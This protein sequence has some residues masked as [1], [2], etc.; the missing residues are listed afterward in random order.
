MIPV[1]DKIYRNGGNPEV[2]S[3]IPPGTRTVLD[4]G[5]GAGDNAAALAA[6]GVVVDG[7]TLSKDEMMMSR[8]FCRDVKLHNLEQGL[9]VGLGAD[10]DCAICSHVLEHICWPDR[11]LS[12][13][14]RL[15]RPQG[16][17]LIIAL[18]NLL[19]YKNRWR[20]LQG[21]FD[22]TDS[23]LMDNTHFRWYTFNTARQLLERNGFVVEQAFG[24]GSIPLWP[25]RRLL[26]KRLAKGIDG[27]ATRVWPGLFGYQMVYLARPA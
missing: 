9:P 19:Y 14:A 4:V 20:L 8:R 26:G 13:L 22:Y 21:H 15:L 3:M 2:L 27:M 10:Y 11:L 23:G 18:P 7:I 17:V 5:C 1:T 16:G 6:R 25:F 12:D 24:D